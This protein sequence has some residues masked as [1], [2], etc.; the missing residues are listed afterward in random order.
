MP[1]GNG[2]E[3]DA[4]LER[5]EQQQEQFQRDM[6]DLLT[7]QVIQK[8]EI[9]KLLASTIKLRDAQERESEERK[10]ADKVLDARVQATVSAIG[11]LIRRIPPEN[12]KRD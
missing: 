6:R 9:D 12:L 10:E 5:I 7:A 2:N 3:R 1:E 4:R 8:D 11:D